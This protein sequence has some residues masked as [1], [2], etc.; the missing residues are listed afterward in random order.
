MVYGIYTS[1]NPI[2]PHPNHINH[3]IAYGWWRTVVNGNLLSADAPLGGSTTSQNNVNL[4][5]Y[6]HFKSHKNVPISFQYFVG[7]ESAGS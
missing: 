1:P 7:A 3:C 2:Q 6:L 5:M 4:V